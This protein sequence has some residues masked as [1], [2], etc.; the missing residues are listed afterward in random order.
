MRARTVIGVCP[1]CLQPVREVLCDWSAVEGS[2]GPVSMHDLYA[3]VTP[4]IAECR[5]LPC[6][7][8]VLAEPDGTLPLYVVGDSHSN[9]RV[10]FVGLDAQRQKD[11]YLESRSR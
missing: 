3:T 11:N 10:C 7:H 5:Y 9:S 4:A 6:E 8:L 1:E 2:A